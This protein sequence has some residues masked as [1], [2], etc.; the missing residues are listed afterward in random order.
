VTDPYAIDARYYD[1]IHAEHD[2]D[3]GLWASYA[4]RTERPTLEVGCGSGRIALAL[5]RA[6]YAV[7]GVDPSAAMLERARE[8]ASG[9]G[10][11]VSLIE[12]RAQ[13]ASLPTEAFGFV[14]LPADVFLYCADGDEQIALL[15]ALAQ[16]MHFNAVLALDLPGP[17]SWLDPTTNGQ[18][19]LAWTGEDPAGSTLD[20]WQLHED[21]LAEQVR[22]LRVTYETTES[23]GLVR[24]VATEH[25]LRY[26]YRFEAEQLCAQAGLI[27]AGVYGDYNLGPL[28]N[29]SA[30]MIVIAGRATG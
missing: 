26:V 9:E 24:R 2:E 15:R 7:T 11:A 1:L 3:I 14:L 30:R 21:D 10:L 28:T 5:A 18:P 25:R 27:V 17:A 20:V 29:E 6:G 16:A 12:G 13:D 4:G 19:V 23:D 8:Q 22:W